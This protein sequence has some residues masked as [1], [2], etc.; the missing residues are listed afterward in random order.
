MITPFP[1]NPYFISALVPILLS[2][3]D[4]PVLL[5]RRVPT[6]VLSSTP[7]LWPM[8]WVPIF[9]LVCWIVVVIA[10]PRHGNNFE[11]IEDTIEL[12]RTE[13]NSPTKAYIGSTHLDIAE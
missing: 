8:N 7:G 1:E 9:V 11:Q 4:K 12:N 5:L 6:T 10:A 3:M 13:H 2:I